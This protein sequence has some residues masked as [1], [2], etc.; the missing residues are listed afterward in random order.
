MQT[1]CELR[2]FYCIK[3]S[4]GDFTIS[5]LLL[6]T[7]ASFV[8]IA[9]FICTHFHMAKHIIPEK[10]I[11]QSILSK[12]YKS[13]FSCTVSTPAK[14]GS[15]ACLKLKESVVCACV[16]DAIKLPSLLLL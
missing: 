1:A 4:Y 7:I 2:F 11:I 13:R 16:A 5:T 10:L 3:Q 14:V 12:S 6:I 9:N 8:V 15:N